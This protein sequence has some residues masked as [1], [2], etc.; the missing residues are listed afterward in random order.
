MSRTSL[1]GP[2]VFCKPNVTDGDN[3]SCAS[4]IQTLHGACALETTLSAAAPHRPRSGTQKR[5]VLEQL[6][7]VT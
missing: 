6:K 4:V 1:Y 5:E 7:R 2:A 3:W